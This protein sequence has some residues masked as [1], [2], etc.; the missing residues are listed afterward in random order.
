M[1]PFR[2][3]PILAAVILGACGDPNDATPESA[4]I[5]GVDVSAMEGWDKLSDPDREVVTSFIHEARA[6]DS[7]WLE[8]QRVSN[9]ASTPSEFSASLDQFTEAVKN[10]LP[11]YLTARDALKGIEGLD[12][13]EEYLLLRLQAKDPDLNAIAND[14]GK[15]RE[16]FSED[17]G[18]QASLRE[19]VLAASKI[20]GFGK[21]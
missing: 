20:P 9:A 6:L 18:V 13:A 14:V 2:A 21:Q 16:K 7:A 8:L 10:W 12:H 15:I 19:F 11:D 5:N 3:I 4:S 1:H 17:P